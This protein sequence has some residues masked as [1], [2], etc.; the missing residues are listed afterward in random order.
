MHTAICEVCASS[1]S[2][3]PCPSPRSVPPTHFPL[4]NRTRNDV[5][6]GVQRG[7]RRHLVVREVAGVEPTDRIIR[8]CRSHRRPVHVV[9]QRPDRERNV[10]SVRSPR[11]H[12]LRPLLCQLRRR[13]VH[14][15]RGRQ[16]RREGEARLLPSVR[17]RQGLREEHVDCVARGCSLSSVKISFHPGRR[18]GMRRPWLFRTLPRSSASCWPPCLFPRPRQIKVFKKFAKLPA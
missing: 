4:Q 14:R 1:V 11:V 13:A 10:R 7:R 6:E 2:F 5:C 15:L 8:A 17:S 18:R 16:L 12:R 9:Q 3:P